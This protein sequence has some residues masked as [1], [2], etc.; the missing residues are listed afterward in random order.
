[1]KGM[2]QAN[3]PDKVPVFASTLILHRQRSGGEVYMVQRSARSRFMPNALVFPGGKVDRS[4][5]ALFDVAKVANNEANR[6]EQSLGD[7]EL[8][9]T[10]LVAAIR[11]TFEES[12]VLIGH[13]EQTQDLSDKRLKLNEGKLNFLTLLND[14]NATLDYGHLR[15]MSRWVTPKVEA[16]RFDAFFFMAECPTDQEDVAAADGYETLRGRWVSP[17]NALK[18]NHN[19]EISLAPPTLRALETLSRLSYGDWLRYE[20]KSIEAVKPQ[21]LEKAEKFTLVLPGDPQYTPPGRELNRF[22]REPQGWQSIGV[23]F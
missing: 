2:N 20:K 8:A 12:G 17:R 18:L 7:R 4:D 14:I 13:L 6:F 15:F 21:H 10:L 22:I 19:G 1:M 9:Q 5:S 11:E 23:G 16:R 3:A